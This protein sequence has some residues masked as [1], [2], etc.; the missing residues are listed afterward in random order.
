MADPEKPRR[1]LEHQVEAV[2]HAASEAPEGFWCP[3]CGMGYPIESDEI[4]LE[5]PVPEAIGGKA[6][7]LTCRSCNSRD[8][9]VL[10]SHLVKAHRLREI[11]QGRRAL[12]LPG[13]IVVGGIGQNAELHIVPGGT[14]VSGVEAWNR[15]G[16]ADE[17][18]AAIVA[19]GGRPTISIRIKTESLHADPRRVQVGFMRAAYLVAFAALGYSWAFG[20]ND[21]SLGLLRRQIAKPDEEMLATTVMKLAEPSAESPALMLVREP[22]E[23]KSVAV[24]I[25]EQLVLLPG[26]ETDPDFFQRTALVLDGPAARSD[27]SGKFM[28]LPSEPWLLMDFGWRPPI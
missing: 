16:L 28:E 22:K 10:D 1:W 11:E 2:G 19:A 24:K 8:G 12:N 14:L 27:L 4:S 20:I 13:Q 25:A 17:M 15:P 3:L 26:I 23:L 6:I 7:L 9:S 21:E 5:H 18:E